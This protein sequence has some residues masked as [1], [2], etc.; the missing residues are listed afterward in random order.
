M[1]H[2]MAAPRKAPAA[3]KEAVYGPRACPH[4]VCPGLIIIRLMYGYGG[5]LY[6]G[7]EQHLH[8]PVKHV[9]ILFQ[10]EIHLAYMAYYVGGAAGGLVCA[11][12]VGKRRVKK[13]CLWQQVMVTAAYLVVGIR[14]AYNAAVVHLGTRSRKGKHR[15]YGQRPFYG[16][17]VYYEFPGVMLNHRSRGY[18]LCCVYGAA[19][20]YR[21]Q[22]VYIMLFAKLGSLAHGGYSG[23][24]LYAGKLIQLKSGGVYLLNYPVI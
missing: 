16:G 5:V 10:V 3:V 17:F 1:F 19:A 15:H 8:K 13:R 18:K 4:Y 21:K 20:A 24:R 7:S 23:I 14:I 11:Y 6:Y 22:N 2:R 12:G 9:Q